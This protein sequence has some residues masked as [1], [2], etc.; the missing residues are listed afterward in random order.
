MAPRKP[1]RP[2]SCALSSSLQSWY[3]HRPMSTP[4]DWSKEGW[5]EVI[6][7]IIHFLLTKEA[8]QRLLKTKKH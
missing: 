1:S 4:P 6:G 7:T 2:P 3:V 8:E 5:E